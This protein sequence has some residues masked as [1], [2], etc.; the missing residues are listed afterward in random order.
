[1]A[2]DVPTCLIHVIEEGHEVKNIDN[3]MTIYTMK[4]TT[5]KSINWKR[6][7]F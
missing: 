2:K 6:E 1:M 5:R 7:R 4:I 3:T